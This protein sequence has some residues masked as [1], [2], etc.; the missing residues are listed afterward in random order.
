MIEGPTDK[1]IMAAQLEMIGNIG[2]D[3]NNLKRNSKMNN[4]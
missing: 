4:L 3:Q 2:V 1:V